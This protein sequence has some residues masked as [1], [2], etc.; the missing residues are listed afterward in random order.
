MKKYIFAA[1]TVAALAA[2]ICGCSNAGDKKSGN[3]V[4][5]PTIDSDYYR[6]QGAKASGNRLQQAINAGKKSDSADSDGG[7]QNTADDM[8]EAMKPGS[9]KNSGENS[10]K[11]DET[12]QNI[13]ASDMQMQTLTEGSYSKA[14]TKAEKN[15]TKKLALKYAKKQYSEDITEDDLKYANASRYEKYPL[16]SRGNIIIYTYKTAEGK[17][18]YIPVGRVNANEDWKVLKNK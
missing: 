3:A 6:E 17:T 2:L 5:S 16:Y 8:S 1:I 4:P 15:T 13:S 10:S 14:L 9:D 12:N 18:K 7:S 11:K